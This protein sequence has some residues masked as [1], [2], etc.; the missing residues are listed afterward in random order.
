MPIPNISRWIFGEDRDIDV[1][2]L[3]VPREN[4]RYTKRATA[5]D[6]SGFVEPLIATDTINHFLDADG[7]TP[8]TGAA[9]NSTAI[10]TDIEPGFGTH[11]LILPSRVTARYWRGLINSAWRT[12]LSHTDFE[13]SRIWAGTMVRPKL[14]YGPN[15]SLI[16]MGKSELA[17]SAR[18]AADY[19]T[20]SERRRKFA[21]DF[22][23]VL[24]TEVEAWEDFERLSGIEEL[25]LFG[26][27][28]DG[29]LSRKAM[30]ARQQAETGVS[31]RGITY[32][33]KTIRLIEAR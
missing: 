5:A 8:G 33:Q 26:T 9:Y 11:C 25:F 16:W 19:V 30:L 14:N 1:L 21:L 22:P 20:R 27:T 13:V 7:G 2:Y 32:S 28:E 12:S 24:N 17:F 18:A 4:G 3:D 6:T 15:D 23:G 31:G 29:T 10:A